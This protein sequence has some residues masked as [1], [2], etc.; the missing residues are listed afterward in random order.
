MRGNILVVDDEAG[1]REALRMILKPNH[2]VR[3][4][5][6]G[7]EALTQ[8][9]EGQPDLVFLDLRMPGMDGTQVLKAVKS[10]Y[11]DVQ[12]AIV[13]A[14]AGIESARLA[15]R[16]GAIEYLTKPYSVAEVEEIVEKA[17]T[18]RRQS[19]DEQVL[20]AQLTRLTENATGAPLAIDMEDPRAVEEAVDRLESM[21]TSLSRDLRK[22]RELYDL[23]EVTA[24]V[25]HDISN[26][27]TIILSN[28]QFLLRQLDLQSES[29][30]A[31]VSERV[32]KIT[33]A[34]EDCS[35]MIARIKDFVR[36]NS[37]RPMQSLNINE[38]VASVVNL[39]R[40]ASPD[41][42]ANVRF[43]LDLGPV[44]LVMGD[45]VALRTVLVNLIDN[46]LDA[47][48]HEGRIEVATEATADSVV[49]RITDD[50][51][52]MSPEVLKHAKDPFFSSG[53]DH[54]TG[55]GLRAA[56]KVV[57]RHQG[58]LRIDSAQGE[59][60]TVTIELPVEPPVTA[61]P[62]L[63]ID[64][65]AA[66]LTV[67]LAEDEPGMREL[68]ARALSTQGYR[69]LAAADG[70][71]AWRIVEDELENGS[72][73]QGLLVLT[74]QVMPGM[75]GRELG[76]RVKAAAPEVPV[77]LVT[78]YGEPPGD[79]VEDRL[80]EKPFELQDLLDAVDTLLQQVRA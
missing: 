36:A 57:Q 1:P 10:Q 65:D 58:S 43:V 63:S 30:D 22:V 48:G 19:H 78:G 56:D 33:R 59:G 12:V 52:G 70:A 40:G 69:V 21:Q 60:T 24:E 44:P 74:D 2:E 26:F 64:A 80:I 32:L 7:P 8:I 66:P 61:E 37:Q 45:E 79:G 18:V 34:A 75:S 67:V 4:A 13:T 55:I 23:G 50:G 54:G 16:Y 49:I 35:E 42:R 46:G 17:L 76:L 25:T 51:C 20:R 62:A 71:G 14:Y 3:T 41:E 6:S 53:K 73:L 38:L 68:I 9:A 72:A 11:P 15:V 39:K 28:S 31:A 47:M 27:L 29:G 77:L 5:S